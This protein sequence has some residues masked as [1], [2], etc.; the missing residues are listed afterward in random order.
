VSGSDNSGGQA[1]LEGEN[2]RLSPASA[3]L[4]YSVPG[5]SN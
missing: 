1:R 3:G 2:E 4:F 5:V